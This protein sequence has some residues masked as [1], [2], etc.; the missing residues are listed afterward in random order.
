MTG[1][2]ATRLNSSEVGVKQASAFERDT[3]HRM[4]AGTARYWVIGE[5]LRNHR[6]PDKATLFAY[7]GGPG[8]FDWGNPPGLQ[9]DPQLQPL[10]YKRVR[11]TLEIEDQAA[12]ERTRVLQLIEELREKVNRFNS[13]P[14]TYKYI[15][16]IAA[17]DELR[18]RVE[19]V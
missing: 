10:R 3:L 6:L 19:E 2:R 16:P 17:L 13:D 4:A 9:D 7:A 14:D 12:H 15:G 1:P 5:W 8:G 18:K 11:I